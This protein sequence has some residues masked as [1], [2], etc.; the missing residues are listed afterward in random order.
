MDSNWHVALTVTNL[1]D[2]DYEAYIS[3]IPLTHKSAAASDTGMAQQGFTN[4]LH[5]GRRITLEAGFN[6]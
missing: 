2:E 4:A 1:L 6:F 5:E 3:K